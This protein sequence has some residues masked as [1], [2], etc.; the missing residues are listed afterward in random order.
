M[1]V[2]IG[3]A[4]NYLDL[5]EKLKVFLTTNEKLVSTG[6]QW[7]ILSEKNEGFPA[8]VFFKAPG[9]TGKENIFINIRA[10][11]DTNLDVYNWEIFGAIGYEDNFGINEQPSKEFVHIYLWQHKIPYWFVSV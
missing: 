5:L 11:F 10:A 9:L 4:D 6:Q 3:T 1:A 7:E 8:Q 2:E